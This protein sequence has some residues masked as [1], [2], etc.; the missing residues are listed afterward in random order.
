MKSIRNNS[1]YVGITMLDNANT[2]M[3]NMYC[4]GVAPVIVL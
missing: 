1:E 4:Y 3:L 2:C